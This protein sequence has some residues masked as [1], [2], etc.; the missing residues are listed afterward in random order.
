MAAAGGLGA[1]PGAQGDLCEC[2]AGT[3][4]LWPPAISWASLRSVFYVTP[5]TLDI[6]QTLKLV[7]MARAVPNGAGIGKD[8]M[9][10]VVP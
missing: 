5:P 3:A 7:L 8:P 6:D 2:P 4:C 9:E 1:Q 10:E